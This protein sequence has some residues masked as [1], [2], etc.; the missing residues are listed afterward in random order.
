MKIDQQFQSWSHL[1]K[2]KM[3]RQRKG[4]GRAESK[5]FIAYRSKMV[6]F[7]LADIYWVSWV[8]REL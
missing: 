8:Q 2:D 1:E 4:G 6:K 7:L 3:K 5:T